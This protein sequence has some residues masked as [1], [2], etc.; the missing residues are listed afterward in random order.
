MDAIKPIHVRCTTCDAELP[1]EYASTS[2]R[3]CKACSSKNFEVT[4]QVV[5]KDELSRIQASIEATIGDVS[6]N[7]N[8][9][10]R[11]KVE[12]GDSFPM[13]ERQRIHREVYVN[14]NDN[15]YREIVKDAET[16]KIVQESEISLSEHH[17]RSNKPSS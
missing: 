2:G 4:Y 3:S 1:S 10:R 9:K 5:D 6:V 7:Q 8:V 14:K 16:G 17:K 15:T 12:Y 11:I 13:D